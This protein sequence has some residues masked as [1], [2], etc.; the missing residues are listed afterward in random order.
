MSFDYVHREN[1]I[2]VPQNYINKEVSSFDKRLID[3]V[4]GHLLIFQ[5]SFS[6]NNCN[7]KTNF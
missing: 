2:K 7:T 6:H 3:Q 1:V 4:N 5:R